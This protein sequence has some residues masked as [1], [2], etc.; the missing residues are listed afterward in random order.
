MKDKLCITLHSYPKA[1]KKKGQTRAGF[2]RSSTTSNK[3]L[4]IVIMSYSTG[5]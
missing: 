1:D 2:S 3:V 4:S 5:K